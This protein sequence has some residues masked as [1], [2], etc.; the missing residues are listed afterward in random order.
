MRV[1]RPEELV[2]LRARPVPAGDA[3]DVSL[4]ARIGGWIGRALRLVRR[5]GRRLRERFGRGR[6]RDDPSLRQR[7]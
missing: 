4:A 6:E 5:V 2:R 7:V 1:V 3:A